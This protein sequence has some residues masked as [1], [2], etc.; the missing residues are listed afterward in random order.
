VHEQLLNL[1]AVQRVRLRAEAE[2]DA[3]D[4]GSLAPRDQQDA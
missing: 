3:A 2:L 4:E 1:G